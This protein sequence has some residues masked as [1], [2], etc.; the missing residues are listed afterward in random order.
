M[1]GHRAVDRIKHLISLKN[2]SLVLRIANDKAEI[3]NELK[4]HKPP[5]CIIEHDFG[6]L[7][8]MEHFRRNLLT[9]FFGDIFKSSIEKPESIRQFKAYD[10]LPEMIQASPETRY[11]I[12]SHIRGSGITK[13]EKT[14]YKKFPEVM[15]VMGFTN[16]KTNIDYLLNLFHAYYDK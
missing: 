14:V 2:L 5:I 7:E 11:V 6:S 12:T 16:S 8:M 10:L 15:K 4:K 1:C 13:E 9:K 3:L